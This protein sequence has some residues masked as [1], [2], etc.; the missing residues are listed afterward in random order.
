M[1]EEGIESA[2]IMEDDADWDVAI[3]EEMVLLS[4]ALGKEGE[5]VWGGGERHARSVAEGA[6][7]QTPTHLQREGI[8]ADAPY[9]LNWDVMYLGH[10]IHINSKPPT[11]GFSYADPTTPAFA[12][13]GQHQYLLEDVMEHGVKEGFRSVAVPGGVFASDCRELEKSC[14]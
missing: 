6:A 10:C 11:P 13:L 1:V 7:A 14:A 9:G 4:E 5:L 2:L 3:K 12:Q 8:R